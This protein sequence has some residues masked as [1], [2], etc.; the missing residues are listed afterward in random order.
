MPIKKIDRPFLP[1]LKNSQIEN[2]FCT[3]HYIWRVCGW[4]FLH[5]F[6][7]KFRRPSWNDVKI[8]GFLITTVSKFSLILLHKK[9]LF[10]SKHIFLPHQSC[11]RSD[12]GRPR[13]SWENKALILLIR[14]MK[15]VTADIYTP[16]NKNYSL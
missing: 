15:I 9:I 6:P 2:I 5:L 3:S 8:R 13:S 11:C 14:V 7:S 16:N 10:L 12:A 4:Q 1:T